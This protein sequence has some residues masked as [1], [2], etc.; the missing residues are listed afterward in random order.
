MQVEDTEE[1]FKTVL[2]AGGIMDVVELY[3]WKGETVIHKRRDKRKGTHSGHVER[4]KDG[5]PQLRQAFI[6]NKTRIL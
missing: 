4:T 2:K 6:S 5:E 3:P 1:Y